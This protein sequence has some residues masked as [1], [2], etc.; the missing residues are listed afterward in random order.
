MPAPKVEEFDLTALGQLPVVEGGRVKPLD[1]F[2]RNLL[3]IVSS[4]ETFKEEYVDGG[5]T[6]ART[7]PAIRWLIDS[8]ATP[9]VA[10]NYKVI[11]VDNPEVLNTLGL[12]RRKGYQ[13]SMAEIV[14][15]D[16]EPKDMPF[17]QRRLGKLVAQWHAARQRGSKNMTVEERKAAEFEKKLG[18]CQA[19]TEFA[20]E[21]LAE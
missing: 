11:R 20:G 19:L 21:P 4:K 8:I 5:S 13:Y 18:L 7:Q 16:D 3:R 15:R 1:T 9:S 14:F 2:A 12:T 17:P 10:K 6:K